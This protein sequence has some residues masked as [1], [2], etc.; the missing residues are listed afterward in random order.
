M[1]ATVLGAFC[2]DYIFV[3][4]FYA[5][6][7]TPERLWATLIFIGDEIVVC[8]AIE[9][10]HRLSA[11]QIAISEALERARRQEREARQ[12]AELA[13]EARSRFFASASH[14]LRQPLQALRLFVDV[15]TA[16]CAGT[17]M[18]RAA[19]GASRSLTSAES[20]VHALLDV[21]RIDTGAARLNV[22]HVAVQPLFDTLADEFA[23]MAESRG[24]RLTFFP[25][26]GGVD[27]DPQALERIL[28]NLIA[29]A[30]RY[31]RAGGILIGARRR[32]DRLAIQVWDTGDGIEEQALG[33]I[34]EEFYQLGNDH[35]DREQGLGLG[36]AIVRKLCAALGHEVA[37][38]SRKGRGTV[39]TVTLPLAQGGAA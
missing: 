19:E 38:R 17:P 9:G 35:R 2:A 7:V 23:P 4:P 22:G 1:L 29:N 8:G 25:C 28:R 12:A 16:Q 26:P 31:T 18:A 13:T 33:H 11:R 20:L 21:A 3:P 6:E 34:W 27:S 15:L 14:D 5:L 37:V 32:G 30:V 24:L 10:L 36:L 39:F